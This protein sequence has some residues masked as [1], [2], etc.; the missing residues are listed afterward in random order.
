MARNPDA[1]SA[2]DAEDPLMGRQRSTAPKR[3]PWD[4]PAILSRCVAQ[5]C[6]PSLVGLAATPWDG[7]AVV[8]HNSS[9][10]NRLAPSIERA[11]H[12]ETGLYVSCSNYVVRC[13][14][15]R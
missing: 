1:F 11:R 8:M 9:S 7:V 10:R 15:R 6:Q 4:L 12:E 2:Y 5:L 14:S 3:M 13:V